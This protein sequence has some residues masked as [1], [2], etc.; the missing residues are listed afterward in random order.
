[1]YK[2]GGGIKTV[3]YKYP[4]KLPDRCVCVC[5]CVYAIPMGEHRMS[6]MGRK[7]NKRMNIK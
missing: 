1:M 7:R 4:I 5:V 3:R 2:Q 6:K